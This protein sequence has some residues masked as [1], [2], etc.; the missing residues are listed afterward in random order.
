MQDLGLETKNI[1]FLDFDCE[2]LFHRYENN[3]QLAIELRA[4]DTP[5]NAEKCIIPG[6]P[7]TIATRCLPDQY[8]AD[9]ETV[10]KDYQEN[11]GLLD[12]LVKANL[13]EP[14]GIIIHQNFVKFEVVRVIDGF[15]I[16]E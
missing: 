6:S 8:F 5:H 14:T 15:A 3:N 16:H 13:V 1:R 9:T 4:S 2:I 7:I 12:V 10:I 11:T